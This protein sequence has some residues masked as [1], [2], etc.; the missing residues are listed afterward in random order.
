MRKIFFSI[1]FSSFLPLTVVAQSISLPVPFTTQAPTGLWNTQPWADACEESV[2]IM[3]THFYN[4]NN[5]STLDTKTA[6]ND[7]RA[8]VEIENWLFGYNKD[9]NA[10]QMAQLINEYLPWRA[11]AVEYPTLEAIKVEIEAGRPVIALVHGRGLNNPYFR[12]VG[13]D[14]HTVILKGYNDTTQVFLSNEPGVNRGLDY[15][16]PYD[17]LMNALHDF[18]PNGQTQSGTPTVL[19]TDVPDLS[20]GTLIKLGNHPGVYYIYGRTKYP[21]ASEAAFLAHGFKWTQIR[22]LNPDILGKFEDGHY[23]R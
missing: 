14:Y 16:Y 2:T 17:T 11:T 23:L 8:I 10:A 12:A 21:I 1:F 6:T 5:F 9:T 18:V 22:T 3:L 13:P 7:I 15:Q 20:S 4:G 19:F